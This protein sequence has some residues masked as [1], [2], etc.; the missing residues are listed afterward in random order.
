MASFFLKTFSRATVRHSHFSLRLRSS[1]RYP[2]TDGH[3][4]QVLQTV[5]KP[6]CLHRSARSLAEHLFD[7]PSKARHARAAAKEQRIHAGVRS[8]R[9]SQ[10]SSSIVG[11]QTEEWETQTRVYDVET[12]PSKRLRKLRRVANRHMA[13]TTKRGGGAG[14][15]QNCHLQIVTVPTADTAGTGMVLHF[16]NETYFFGQ[17]G[18]G[19]QRACIQRGV[20][21]RKMGKLF[22]TGPSEWKTQGGLIGLILSI[23]DIEAA[24]QAASPESARKERLHI[25]MPPR[26]QHLLACARR[27]VFRS[28]MPLTVHESKGLHFEWQDEPTYADDNLRVWSVPLRAD[29]AA[30]SQDVQRRSGQTMN[31]GANADG[32]WDSHSPEIED[33]QA[34][35]EKIVAEMFESEWRRDR[36]FPVPFHEVKM[37][38]TVWLRDP[39]TKELQGFH[40]ASHD[41]ASQIPPEQIVLVRDPWPASLF[42][43]LPKASNLP[44]N[45]SMSYIVKGYPQRGTFD[46]VKAK[47]LG[48]KPGPAFTELIEGG[49]ITLDDG[50]VVTSAMALGPKR[51]AKGFAFFDIPSI[52]HLRS[53]RG[54]LESQPP[55]MLEGVSAVVWML[56]PTVSSGEIFDSVLRSLPN[57]KHIV[58]DVDNSP[59]RVT[60]ESVALS[61][62]MTARKA[63]NLFPALNVNNTL[64]YQD[65]RQRGPE[66]H[67]SSLK[68][69]SG[70]SLA[71]AGVKISVQRAYIA[72]ESEVPQLFDINSIQDTELAQTLEA[73]QRNQKHDQIGVPNADLTEPEIITLGTGSALPSKYRNVSATL[74]RMPGNQGNY[75]FD[76][77]ENTIGQLRRLY[78][79][80]E[81]RSILQNLRAIWISHLHGDHHIGTMSVLQERARAFEG[82]ESQA[83]RTIYLI[84]EPH[85]LDF[86]REYSSVEPDIMAATGL[87][88]IN[89]AQ[90]SGMTLHGRPFSFAESTSAVRKIETVQVRHCA[91]AQAVSVTFKDGFKISYSGDC[92]PSRSFCRIGRDSDVL[93]HEATFDDGMEGD[94]IAKKHSTTAE[95]LGVGLNMR[96]KN[97]VLTHFSQRYAKIPNFENIKLPNDMHFED[98]GAKQED[99]PVHDGNGP[100]A[101]VSEMAPGLTYESSVYGVP[102]GQRLHNAAAQMHIAIAFDYMR[103]KV[104]EIAGLKTIYPEI[105]ALFDE[106]E[107]E[108]E[109]ERQERIRKEEEKLTS[110]QQK[111]LEK[112]RNQQSKKSK[113]QDKGKKGNQDGSANKGA[114][115]EHVK[116]A[117]PGAGNAESDHSRNESTSG[118]RL[119]NNVY[120][121]QLKEEALARAHKRRSLEISS[122][123][124]QKE[125]LPQTLGQG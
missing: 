76:C 10:T 97:V 72:D 44:G 74:L 87:V 12:K 15:R 29:T 95:A 121:R 69:H 13:E 86:V 101:S 34:L 5:P 91:G 3:S 11:D 16:D 7:V 28:K 90:D 24:A 122:E 85:M 21:L 88:P 6:R 48:V 103:V 37:P 67:G 102:N 125:G 40:C 30:Q 116:A 112:Q 117:E 36:L 59:N 39:V 65:Q 98:V 93:I 114:H 104:S 118:N 120:K 14:A 35:R 8:T 124:G 51:E 53:I 25:H 108:A 47:S 99:G 31:D 27:F 83:D 4:L 42:G 18:E 113:G 45:V 110:K 77:G 22:L 79:A 94:A 81:L 75:L 100:S 55:T 106:K 84:S 70:I 82:L 62:L 54:M 60:F 109:V 66:M 46:P 68:D 123:V 61:N 2:S 49:S 92:R 105:Q 63:P 89:C 107:H 119:R 71:K 96:A 57:I 33:E 43:D 20:S 50:T 23:A 56:G 26:G 41:S 111:H 115:G 78:P 19:F 17:L 73:L 64:P 1:Q 38:A 58:S 9:S 52:P 32:D 80:S